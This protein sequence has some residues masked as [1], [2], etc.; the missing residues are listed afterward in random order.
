MSAISDNTPE[1]MGDFDKG[2]R[3]MYEG[4]RKMVGEHLN[5]DD[6]DV[7][8]WGNDTNDDYGEEPEEAGELVNCTN[9]NTEFF[10][11]NSQQQ[12]PNC[13]LLYQEKGFDLGFS[14]DENGNPRGIE[15][16][17]ESFRWGSYGLDG[18]EP[19]TFRYLKDISD[20][21]LVH[22]IGHLISNNR[23]QTLILML[24][25]ARYRSENNIFVPNYEE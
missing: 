25:E 19:V 10:H 2:V 17:R 16:S 23:A 12:C 15:Y 21:H 3:D 9:C 20:T 4:L 1:D 11:S 22:I 6:M 8:D 24:E 7:V 18:T 5:D 13:G 14:E